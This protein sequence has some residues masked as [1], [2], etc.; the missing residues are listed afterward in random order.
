[1]TPEYIILHT[2]A[3]RGDAPPEEIDRWHSLRKP[4]FR[5]ARTR[6][7]PLRHIGYHWYIERDGTLTAGRDED[8][9][10]AHC[11]EAGMN[12]KSLGICLEGH[13]DY[14]PWTEAQ[15]GALVTLLRDIRARHPRIAVR[16]TA[17]LIGHREA[18]APKTCPGRMI[19]MDGVRDWFAA[20]VVARG[21]RPVEAMPL[22]TMGNH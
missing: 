16:G 22:Q 17:A 12:N 6:T 11:I 13:G 4:P 21:V 1:M 9:V 19:D 10:G 7:G 3:F 20:F 14:E 18:G 15:F 2:A 8:E 5:R